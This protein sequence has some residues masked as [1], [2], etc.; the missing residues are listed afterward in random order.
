[1]PIE[2][3]FDKASKTYDENCVVQKI[4]GKFLIAK[5][6]AYAFEKNIITDF[7]CGTGISTHF[8]KT[9][10]SESK[11]YGIDISKE[12]LNIAQKK[13][14]QNISFIQEDF[15]KQIFPI[16]HL[17]LAFSNMAFQ[18]SA[19]L[20]KTLNHLFLQLKNNGV[21][22]FTIPI[23]GTFHQLKPQHRNHFYDLKALKSMLMK[24]KFK[25][26]EISTKSITQTYRSAIEAVRSIKKTGANCL[27]QSNTKNHLLGKNSIINFFIKQKSINSLTYNI[28]YIVARKER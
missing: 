25:I 16:N 11:I 12:S 14:N 4:T 5:L 13:Q 27:I 10:F 18:W 26:L 7:G 9:K 17:D 2:H 28:A 6:S 15:N 19:N 20:E 22:A 8:L 21:I 1:M 3:A 23:K 24:L